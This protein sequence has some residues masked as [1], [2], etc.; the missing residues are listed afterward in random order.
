MKK[1]ATT[2][3]NPEP[4]SCQNAFRERVNF[5]SIFVLWLMLAGL[6]YAHGLQAQVV[7]CPTITS[8]RITAVTICSGKLVDS[9]QAKT[10]ALSP[11]TI[12]FV[13]FDT[14]YAN[15]YKGQ[16]GVHLGEI[17]PV[18]GVVTQKNVDFPAN[19]NVADKTY[20]VYACLKPAPTDPDCFP[21]ALITVTVAPC[22][23]PPQKCIPI[24][25]RKTRSGVAIR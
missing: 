25:I 22:L 11:Y 5:R 2:T 6:F 20:Y 7:D 8:S 23:C 24:T 17:T 15:P 18:D 1:T 14:L 13:R 19:T 10:T 9:L 16:N 3:Q 21:F 12:E 4:S